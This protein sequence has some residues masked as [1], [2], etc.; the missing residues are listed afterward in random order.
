MSSLESLLSTK[1]IE[2]E[3]KGLI[4]N[5]LSL[6]SS[7]SSS[8]KIQ[9]RYF[10]NFSSNDYLGLANNPDTLQSIKNQLDRSGFGSGASHLICG[11]HQI[12]QELETAL[13]MFLQR[14]SA[15]TF[16]TGYMANLAILQSLAKKGDLIISDKLNHASIID[17]I[18]L[19]DA[20]SVRYSHGDLIALESRLKK[21]ATNKWVVTDSVFSMDGDIAPL[22]NIA[23]LCK[24]YDANLIVDD[25]HGFGVLGENGR[26]CVE[27]FGLTQSDCPVLMGTFGKAL[28]GY[29]AFVSGSHTLTSYLKQFA[30]PYIYTTAQPPAIA[31]GNLHNLGIIQSKP[32]IKQKIIENI[33]HFKLQ[34]ASKN[35]GLLDSDTAIQ[36]IVIRNTKKLKVLDQKLKEKGLLVGAIRPPTVAINSDRLRIALSASHSFEQ[37]DYLVSHLNQYIETHET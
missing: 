2:R 21:Q 18:K 7:Q 37:I 15:I 13:A 14:D 23:D 29:G 1:L 28:G 19:S 4:R 5:R 3:Q 27:H 34:C 22:R 26:G 10:L 8:I 12:H 35:I 11:H 30:R 25:A 31:A 33:K 17:G 9:N 24:K 36:P 32:Q 16:S 20:Q 6:Q